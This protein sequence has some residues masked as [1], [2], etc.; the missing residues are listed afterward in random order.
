MC[1]ELLYHCAK[2]ANGFINCQ[3]GIKATPSKYSLASDIWAAN[4]E[5]ASTQASESSVQRSCF[6]N[7]IKLLSHLEANN[8]R[9]DNFS[10]S[11]T[12]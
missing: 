12:S 6:P 8:S 3:M 7:K 10:N 5:T 4:A 11:S 2:L 9:L 1:F